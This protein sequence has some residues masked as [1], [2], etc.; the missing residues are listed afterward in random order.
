MKAVFQEGLAKCGG[1]ARG[2]GD[3]AGPACSGLAPNLYQRDAINRFLNP[4]TISFCSRRDG[5]A[6]FT[7]RMFVR[8]KHWL[9]GAVCEFLQCVSD[10]RLWRPR[11]S[12]R[13]QNSCP[14]SAVE[15][16]R[17]G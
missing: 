9:S 11:T 15:A 13:T 6:S 8:F 16:P 3:E 5:R 14:R 10:H 17:A 12:I 4:A 7:S 1:A 2:G